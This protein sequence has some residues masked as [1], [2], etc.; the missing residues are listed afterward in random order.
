MSEEKETPKL[1]PAMREGLKYKIL[2]GMQDNPE[3]E[4][5]VMKQMEEKKRKP[6]QEMTRSEK[7]ALIA[8]KN[9]KEREQKQEPE[10]LNKFHEETTK[11]KIEAITESKKSKL[12]LKK[13]EE[14]QKEFKKIADKIEKEQYKQIKK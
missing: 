13:A 1:T 6:V 9:V 4:K 8:F 5:E 10:Y 7:L 11:K 12:D 3:F 2:K 14:H